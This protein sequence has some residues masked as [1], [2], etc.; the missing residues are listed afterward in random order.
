MVHKTVVPGTGQRDGLT[1]EDISRGGFECS[2]IIVDQLRK[3]LNPVEGEEKT[4]PTLLLYDEK[5]L[6]FFEQIMALE[7]YYLTN[8]EIEVLK[9][10]ANK[11]SETIREGSMIVE[12]GS[13]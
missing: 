3:G 2:K 5:G 6:I 12:L 10:Q 13:G 7:E 8:S 4:M 9:R 1:V 11:I